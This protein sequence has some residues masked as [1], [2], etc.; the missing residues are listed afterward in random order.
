MAEMS[1]EEILRND[2]KNNYPEGTTTL[3]EYAYGL[4]QS[5]DS[6]MK[7][8]RSG[9]ALFLY[10]EVGDGVVELHVINGGMSVKEGMEHL[11]KALLQLR[12]NGYK[13]ADIYYDNKNFSNI[14]NNVPTF[15]VTTEKVNEGEGK[16]YLTKVRL[17]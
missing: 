14:L 9:N 4:R 16:T 1:I 15:P 13:E 12:E 10:E 7:M 6:G 17:A 11:F 8:I 5:L 3:E 2:L